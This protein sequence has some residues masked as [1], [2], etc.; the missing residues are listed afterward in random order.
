MSILA[1]HDRGLAI[2]RDRLRRDLK[3]II[4]DFVR[5]VFSSVFN[6]MPLVHHSLLKCL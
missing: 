3:R 4:E 6:C 2:D 5:L 1:T